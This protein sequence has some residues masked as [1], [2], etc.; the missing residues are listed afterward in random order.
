VL[1]DRPLNSAGGNKPRVLLT[2][3]VQAMTTDESNNLYL[4]VKSVVYKLLCM[5]MNNNA[6]ESN[7]SI[8]A[9]DDTA[10]IK[11]GHVSKA[12]FQ[13]CDTILW[14]KYGLLVGNNQCLRCIDLSSKQVTTIWTAPG[15]I[16]SLAKGQA[17]DAE[18]HIYVGT[19]LGIFRLSYSGP[20]S[21]PLIEPALT[22]GTTLKALRGYTPDGL[23]QSSPKLKYLKIRE[24]NLMTVNQDAD[25]DSG[26]INVKLKDEDGFVPSFCVQVVERPE[27]KPD[28]AYQRA[29][30]CEQTR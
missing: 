12:R 20:Y 29:C 28:S 16:L 25:M 10:E 8:V 15:P 24:G 27:S 7:L 21:A 14:T 11:D 1:L 6:G 30:T 26:W 19:S 22:K 3:R 5:N 4:T 17:S 18:F 2:L 9:G 23:F 13:C